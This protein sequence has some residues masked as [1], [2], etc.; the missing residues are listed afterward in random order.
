MTPDVW[1]LV[2]SLLPNLV[3]VA[4]T[5]EDPASQRKDVGSG[6]RLFSA[7]VAISGYS[8]FTFIQKV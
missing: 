3:L 6:S 4:I 5:A 7:F 8:T 2:S 1:L